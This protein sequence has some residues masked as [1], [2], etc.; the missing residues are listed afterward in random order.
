MANL[1]KNERAAAA[2]ARAE[3]MRREAEAKTRRTRTLIVAVT[4]VVVAALVVWAV[5][6][7]QG[8]RKEQALA[9]QGPSIASERGGLINGQDGAKT[10]VTVYA[11][12]QCPAC[13]AWEGEN[14]PMLEQLE[15]D[16]S[17][18]IEYVPV[19]ILDRFSGGTK[20]STRS[21]SA[22]FC[23]MDSDPDKFVAFNKA[24]FDNQPPE[25]ASG[26]PNEQL[27]AIAGTAG[28]SEAG[29]TCIKDTKY[30][31]FAT[32]VTNDA[33]KDRPE[34]GTPYVL[35]NGEPLDRNKGQTITS[36][37]K[38]AGITVPAATG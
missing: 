14:S 27:V 37:L 33:T 35:V 11:D 2:R 36:A 23:V 6:L 34:F 10:T 31:G 19:A 21:A 28:V 18:K 26:L 12:Y 15:A 7:V 24:L 25:N 3:Q 13:K 38:E 5:V 17:I 16:G 8:A 29:Q 20:Y 9:S 4:A 32:K 30:E 1:S 22:A